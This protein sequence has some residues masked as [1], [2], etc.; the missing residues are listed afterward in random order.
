MDWKTLS[1]EHRV[2]KFTIVTTALALAMLQSSVYAD[3]KTASAEAILRFQEGKVFHSAN[4][5]AEARAK[6]IQSLALFSNPNV[7]YNL[8]S[9]EET[10]GTP[11][12]ALRYARAFLRHPKADPAGIAEIKRSYLPGLLAKTGHATVIAPGGSLVIVDGVSAGKTPF[13]DGIDVMP[14]KHTF[15]TIDRSVDVTFAAGE[16]KE[17]RF[18]GSTT[19]TQAQA[20]VPVQTTPVITTPPPVPGAEREGRSTLS[21]IIPG[22]LVG[23]GVVGITIGAVFASSS[24]A[25][26]RDGEQ[27]LQGGAC[28]S[29]TAPSCQ[30]AQDKV[31]SSRSQSRL[32]TIMY[33]GGGL[34][35]AGGAAAFFFWP[36]RTVRVAPTVG[37]VTVLGTF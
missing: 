23:L 29:L 15:A 11:T 10:A 16:T 9:L 35:V 20:A 17:V 37:G 19:G 5:P 32:S 33:V 6:Y 26:T 18:G 22:A 2:K 14:G 31:D 21:Y 25:T 13:D 36:N 7:L 27:L 28:R 8:V 24:N 34:V 3:D 12:D 1:G 30:P 4:K